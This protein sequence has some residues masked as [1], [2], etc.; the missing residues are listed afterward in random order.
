MRCDW[1]N[2]R[3]APRCRVIDLETGRQNLFCTLADEETGEYERWDTEPDDP[4]R[5]RVTNGRVQLVRGQTR[6]RIEP[7]AEGEPYERDHGAQGRGGE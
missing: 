6:L 2:D 3:T 7:L 5:L 1:R 4:R